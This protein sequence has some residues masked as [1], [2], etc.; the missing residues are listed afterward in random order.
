MRATKAIIDIAAVQHN[1]QMIKALAPKSKIMAVLKADAYGHGILE[2]GRQLSDVSCLGVACLQ[3]AII[4]REGGV[5]TDIVLLE[6]F[7][8]EDEIPAIIDYGFSL[9]VHQN[10]QLD[11]LEKLSGDHKISVWLKIDTGM[12]RLGFCP[13]ESQK[14]LERLENMAVVDGIVIMSHLACADDAQS[15]MTTEQVKLFKE[16]LTKISPQAKQYPLSMANSAA[17]LAWPEAHFQLVR[18]GLLLYGV[19]P[20]LA[21]PSHLDDGQKHGLQPVMTLVS[22]LIALR[23]IKA[24]ETV[25]YGANWTA[26]VDTWI[27]TIGIGYGDGYPRNLPNGTPVW[28]NGVEVPL[29][30]RVSMD[31]ITVD[32]GAGTNASIGDRVVLWGKE[33]PIE[34]VATAAATIPYELLCGITQRVPYEYWFVEND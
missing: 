28:L 15:M 22:E 1:L 23:Q 26:T 13:E 12:H 2:M 31:M 16:T 24:G 34:K 11:S 21:D 4:L 8:G 17:I 20:L 3:E 33:L 25:S 18:P 6:G 9:V 32:L 10:N 27:G 14:A 7:F 5:K 30:G 29:A 19:S